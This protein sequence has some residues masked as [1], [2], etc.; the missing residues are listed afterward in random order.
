[1]TAL[2]PLAGEWVM[3]GEQMQMELVLDYTPSGRA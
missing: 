2:P 3:Q 1:M